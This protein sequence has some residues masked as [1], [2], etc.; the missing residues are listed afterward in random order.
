MKLAGLTAAAL[1]DP[2]LARARQLAQRGDTEQVDL[3][4]PAVAAPVRHRRPRRRA[5]GPRGHRDQPG[6]RR[7]GRGA[8][9]PARPRPGRGLPVLGDA[10]A[11]AALARAP[12]RSGGGWPCCAGSPTRVRGVAAARGRRAGPLG[13]AAAAQGPRRPRAGGAAGGRRGRARGRGHA[14]W[15]RSPTPGSTWSPSAAS[16]PSAAASSTSS[17]R[18][19]STRCGSSSGATRSR[20]S[21]A[22]RSPTSG[23]STRSTGSGRRRAASCCSP[24]TSGTGRRHCRTDHPQLAEMLDKLA[25]GIPVEGMESLAPALLG[26]TDALE[27]LL[28]LHAGR[29]PCAALRPRADPDPGARPGAHQRRIPGGELGRGGRGRRGADRPRRRRFQNPCRGTGGSRSTRPALVVAEPVRGGRD[30]P[31]GAGR[32]MARGRVCP[33][34][35]R[36]STTRSRSLLSAQP[37]PLYHGETARVV[38]DLKRLGRRRLA[39]RAGLRGARS[40]PACGRGAA[41]RRPRHRGRRR[42]HRAA[43]AGRDHRHHRLAHAGLPRRRRP[44]RGD[45]RHRHLRRARRVHQGHAQDAEPAAQ[46]D[47]PA[48]AAGRRLRGARAARHRPVRGDGPAHGQRRRPR[49]PGDRVRGRP[50]AASPATGSS[51]R[52]TSSTSCPATSAASRRPCTRWAARTGRRPSRGPARRSGRSPRSSSSSTRCGRTRRA[53]PSGR[54]RRGSASWRTRSRTRRRPTSSPRSKKSRSTWRSRCRWTG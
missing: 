34:R 8:R 54:T 19:R 48:G 23:P 24:T 32:A 43:G 38:D 20:R 1:A 4:A 31:R 47:R 25:A 30:D 5:A 2:A 44:A 7:P 11:R 10:A 17:R 13:A 14:G 28:R 39:G 6:G 12:T 26:G 27:L 36:S 22:S 18:P 51:C 52:P 3:T 35:S 15:P 9:L 16:S 33:S 40:G 37:V 50:S 41:R 53:T 42:A 49:I 46:P 21:A 29:D 45:H